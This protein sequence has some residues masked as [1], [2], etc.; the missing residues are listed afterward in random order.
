MKLSPFYWSHLLGTDGGLQPIR[1][2]L[3]MGLAISLLVMAGSFAGGQRSSAMQST[4]PGTHAG[5]A[6]A[7][8]WIPGVRGVLV[9]DVGPSPW[10]SKVRPDGVET[11]LAAMD[12]PDDLLITAFLQKVNF[13]ASAESCR[14]DWW[15]RSRKAKIKRSDVQE[16]EMKDGIARV[17][18]IVHEFKGRRFEQKVVHAYMG[19]GNLCAEIHLSKVEFKPE[20]QR[21]FEEVLATARLLPDEAG[22][23]QPVMSAELTSYIG[24]ASRYYL[25]K[26][27]PSAATFYQKALDMEKQ[28]R[29]LGNGMFRVM[30]D[31]LGMAY[32]ISGNLN[33]AK[34][35]FAYGIS[36]DAE[37]PMYYYNMACIFGEMGKMEEALEQLQLAYKYR[38]NTI[39]GEGDIPDPVKDDSFRNF[40]KDDTFIQAVRGM[41]QKH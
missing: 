9:L 29:T 1:F 27:Y 12:R 11:G 33:K 25:Q 37:Y 36:Q 15:P 32:A 7:R 6:D 5:I 34:E 22:D 23:E 30:V 41:Q 24:K 26:D 10:L 13:P 3:R 38:A 8:I 16:P 2:R 39:P 40:A 35:T 14:N 20:D 19:S 31:N 4:A 28:K 18:Y 21:L 17:E